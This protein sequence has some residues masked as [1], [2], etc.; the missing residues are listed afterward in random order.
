MQQMKKDEYIKLRDEIHN[1]LSRLH[2]ELVD[3]DNKYIR[4]AE[5]QQYKKGD[6][7]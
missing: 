7:P 2:W 3:L 1:K 6:A 5:I 4:E